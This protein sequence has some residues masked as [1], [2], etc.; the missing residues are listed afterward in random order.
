MLYLNKID[1]R[2]YLVFPA[3]SL[4]YSVTQLSMC[5][6]MSVFGKVNWFCIRKTQDFHFSTGKHRIQQEIRQ[7]KTPNSKSYSEFP[8]QFTAMCEL[9]RRLR[10]SGQTEPSPSFSSFKL[11]WFCPLQ[12]REVGQKNP[13][14]TQVTKFNN[15]LGKFHPQLPS[16]IQRFLSF[17][18][19]KL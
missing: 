5:E 3:E 18:I 12:T 16:S 13:Q 19:P 1:A 11:G 7:I 9:F 2:V 15:A 4:I 10:L 17:L 6:N 14:R 8:L